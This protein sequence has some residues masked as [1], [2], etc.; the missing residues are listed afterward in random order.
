[1]TDQ[2]PTWPAPAKINLFLRVLGR[3]ADGYHELQTAFQFLNYG[4]A[5]RLRVRTDGLIRRQTALPG[6]P[7]RDD[8]TVRAARL[9]QAFGET[10]LG[11]DIH[12]EKRIPLGA[13]L[14]GGSSDA[15]TTLVALSQLWG[16]GLG[17]GE[18]A[19]LGLRLGADVPVFVRG[20]AAWAEGV[21]ERLVPLEF[22]EV[23]YLVVHPG[24]HVSTAA[25]F[26]AP[27]LTRNSPPGT[28]VGLLGDG[29]RPLRRISPR[30]VLRRVGNDCEALV[31][32][33]YPEVDKA[34]QWLA[35]FGQARM[36]GT[37]A[38]AFVPVDRER[39]GRRLLAQLPVRWQG[40][41]A[42]GRNCSP[43]L[44]GSG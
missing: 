37:G 31:R 17:E 33:Q 29:D 38:A 10:K 8:L 12:V 22:E 19:A 23:W 18:L 20:T 44:S 13:G 7:E 36:T 27:E 16:L 9:L 2:S 41:V 42:Q 34:L 6:V 32:K 5:I 15:A 39:E 28:I 21:G 24:C 4:D 43:L 26:S 25:V 1:M 40:F 14:G 30:G 11:V 3:R 35:Q